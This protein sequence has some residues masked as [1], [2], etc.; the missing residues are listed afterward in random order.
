M[1][2]SVMKSIAQKRHIWFDGLV[3]IDPQS[4]DLILVTEG[5]G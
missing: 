4:I 5:R 2:V 3:T 1:E